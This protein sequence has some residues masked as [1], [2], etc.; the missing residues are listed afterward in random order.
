MTTNDLLMILKGYTI[1]EKDDAYY[2]DLYGKYHKELTYIEFIKTLIN[3]YIIEFNEGNWENKE[4]HYRLNDKYY[5]YKNNI[6]YIKLYDICNII[7]NYNDIVVSRE[8]KNDFK[9]LVDKLHRKI[10]LE[11]LNV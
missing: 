3:I 2:L 1:T 6:K 4:S 7:N 9:L 10:K 5:Y 8:V 11:K